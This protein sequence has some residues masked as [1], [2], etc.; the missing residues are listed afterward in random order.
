[1]QLNEN[2]IFGLEFD[3]IRQ[4]NEMEQLQMQQQQQFQQQYN[5]QQQNLL[6]IN[7]QGNSTNTNLL[8]NFNNLIP[9]AATITAPTI[10]LN[11][12][13]VNNQVGSNNTFY[14]THARSQSCNNISYNQLYAHMPTS[15][16]HYNI[17]HNNMSPSM[18]M[19]SSNNSMNNIL[20]TI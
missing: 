10:A 11:N 8:T 7:R 14:R 17:M 12:N 3:R 16:T 9:T 13:N 20:G 19:N 18:A 15:H 2:D 1:M 5:Q 6:L 4:K